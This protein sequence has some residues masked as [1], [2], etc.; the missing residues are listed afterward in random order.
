MTI[1]TYYSLVNKKSLPITKNIN[2]SL[3]DAF[4]LFTFKEKKNMFKDIV[5]T[6]N[7]QKKLEQEI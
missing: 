7:L 5:K 1:S 6:K 3:H 4:T 2:L